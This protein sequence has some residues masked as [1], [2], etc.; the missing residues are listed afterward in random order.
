MKK[1]EEDDNDDGYD[2]RTITARGG[3][4]LDILIKGTDV[5]VVQSGLV[6]EAV[7][8]ILKTKKLRAGEELRLGLT[9]SSVEEG[10][11][12]VAKLSLFY[13]SVTW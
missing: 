10:S 12:D 3:E 4:S 8:K 5:D 1:F 6:A 11:L 2:R 7:A 13:Q 9:P